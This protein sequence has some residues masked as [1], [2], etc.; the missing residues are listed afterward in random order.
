M[1]TSI[2]SNNSSQNSKAIAHVLSRVD[3]GKLS[4][5]LQHL[6]YNNNGV[7]NIVLFEYVHSGIYDTVAEMERI[8]GTTWFIN[9][10]L[11]DPIVKN[12][13]QH[14][15]A[16]TPGTE[17]YTRRK[18]DYSVDGP[19]RL[20]KYRQFVLRMSRMPSPVLNPEDDDMPPLVPDWTV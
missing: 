11:E 7:R 3:F 6:D 10:V 19:Q 9:D 1:L 18:I 4:S 20:T 2:F 16:N 8:P 5:A 12:S 17:L 13:L 14:L 15:F